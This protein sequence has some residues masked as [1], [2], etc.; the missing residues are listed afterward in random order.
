MNFKTGI[1]ALAIC[2]LFA[3]GCGGGPCEDAEECC[4]KIADAAGVT[5]TCD[6]SEADDDAC[7]AVLDAA[8]STCD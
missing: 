8:G 3:V 5:V 6:Y 4:Q 7:Q 1:F 2:G